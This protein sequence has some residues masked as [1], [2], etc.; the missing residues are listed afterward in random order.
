M[1]TVRKYRA[2]LEDLGVLPFEKAVIKR[3]VGATTQTFATLTNHMT[4]RELIF[5]SLAEIST[6]DFAEKAN[7]ETYQAHKAAAAQAGELAGKQ[8][9]LC[10]KETG[11]KVLSKLNFLPENRKNYLKK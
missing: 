6:Q 7:A 5:M 10:E 3:E 1:E 9:T 4:L 8:R 11:K 2:D